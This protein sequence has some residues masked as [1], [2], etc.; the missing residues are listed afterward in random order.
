MPTHQHGSVAYRIVIVRSYV[1]PGQWGVPQPE[2]SD[3]QPLGRS[4]LVDCC[5]HLCYHDSV[6]CPLRTRSHAGT[7]VCVYIVRMWKLQV[8]MF[9]H[10]YVQPACSVPVVILP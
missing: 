9:L 4:R 10:N 3:P 2:C 8:R 5:G 6:P 1:D 7:Y